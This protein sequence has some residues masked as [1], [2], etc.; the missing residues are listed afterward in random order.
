MICKDFH[1]NPVWSI[2]KCISAN[3]MSWLEV[4]KKIFQMTLKFKISF[5]RRLWVR[6]YP[7]NQTGWSYDTWNNFYDRRGAEVAIFWFWCSQKAI[8]KDFQAKMEDF[9]D[10]WKLYFWKM[11]DNNALYASNY[12]QTSFGKVAQVQR[13]QQSAWRDRKPHQIIFIT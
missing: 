1:Q 10:F 11:C 13:S 5:R 12:D 8:L 6:W 7:Q 3:V 9:W 2:K 4:R